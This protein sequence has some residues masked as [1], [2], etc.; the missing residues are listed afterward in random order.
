MTTQNDP[1][2]QIKSA[3]QEL[4]K[5]IEQAKKDFDEKAIKHAEALEKKSATFKEELRE[6]GMEKLT[7]TKNEA[8][9][10]FKSKMATAE[11]EKNQIVSEAKS[12]AGEASKEIVSAFLN[13]VKN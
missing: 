8:G 9:E 11:S 13:H 3:E 7:T 5:K 4:K 10:L 2:S 12:K 1:I 6:K